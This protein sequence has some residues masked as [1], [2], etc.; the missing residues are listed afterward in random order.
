MSIHR[1][2]RFPHHF[3]AFLHSD[4]PQFARDLPAGPFRVCNG[5]VAYRRRGRVR[6]QQIINEMFVGRKRSAAIAASG[7]AG[8][9]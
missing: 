8:L 6:A 5:R 2:R 9:H 7:S 1:K 3:A 4:L